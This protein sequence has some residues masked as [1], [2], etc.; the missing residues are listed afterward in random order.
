M[1]K[2]LA[3][4]L[5]TVSVAGAGFTGFS[6]TSALAEDDSS[7]E[8]SQVQV[9]GDQ[10]GDR[11]ARRAE[12]QQNLA[13]TLGISVEDLMAAKESGQTVAEIA[14]D[15]GIERADLISSLVEDKQ[16]RL[17]Q[18]VAD[19]ELTQEEADEKAAGL[20]ERVTS[21]VDGEGRGDRGPRGD[22]G[23]G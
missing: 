5:L 3:A 7:V 16:A 11:E 10:D 23:D 17:D 4:A 20:E 12:R 13:D 9:E 2:H 22:R 6:I 19:G 18:A 21:F 15:N 14:A 8:T 1:N